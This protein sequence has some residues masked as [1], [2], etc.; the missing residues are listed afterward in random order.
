MGV[1]FDWETESSGQAEVGKF[2]VLAGGVNKQILGLEVPVENS[3]LVQMDKR[4][5]NLVKESLRLLSRKRR[6][7]LGSHVFLQIKL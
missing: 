5:Q 1:S 2:D 6:I 3:V 4:L 7:T